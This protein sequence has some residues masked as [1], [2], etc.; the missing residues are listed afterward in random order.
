MSILTAGQLQQEEV[1]YKLLVWLEKG[2]T[3]TEPKYAYQYP[4][5]QSQAM[6][7]YWETKQI[8][9]TLPLVFKNMIISAIQL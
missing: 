9:I 2:E 8:W 7:P 3:K 4:T 6:V 5:V 1:P